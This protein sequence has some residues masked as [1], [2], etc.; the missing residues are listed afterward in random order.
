M[1][2]RRATQILAVVALLAA[3]FLLSSDPQRAETQP[4]QVI[5]LGQRV[6]ASSCA[7][8]HMR[9]AEAQVPGLVF[10]HGNHLMIGCSACHSPQPHNDG[11]TDRPPMD[12][13]F[14]CHGINHGAQG[15]LATKEC[16]DC[17]TPSFNLRPRSHTEDWAAKPHADAG[18]A[19]G[20][21]RCLMC[22][23]A[24]T[25]CDA[26]HAEQVPD[27]GKMP[28]AFQ[29]V[30]LVK[31]GPPTV[32]IY[33]QERVTMGQCVSC[34]PDVDD[35]MPGSVIFEHSE[36]LR[37]SY[38]CEVCHVQFP[39]GNDVIER[40][41]ME[42]CY[43]CHGLTHAAS[44]LVAREECEACHPPE[45]DLRPENHTD[46]FVKGEH[47]NRALADGA[48]CGMC[49]EEKFC[50]DCHQGRRLGPDGKPVEPVIPEDHYEPEWVFG[51]HG[52]RFMEQ[53]GMCGS[54]HESQGCKRCH[55]TPMP[56]PADWLEN[57]SAG[58]EPRDCNVCH[59]NRDRCQ[60]CHH[61]QVKR[62]ELVREACTPCH[63]EMNHIP[64]TEIRHK[65]YAEHAVHFDVVKK[66]KERPYRCEDCHVSFGTSAGARAAEVATAHDLRLCY[67]CHGGLDYQNVQIA[68]WK[69]RDLCARCHPRFKDL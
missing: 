47:K 58:E 44:G 13:C 53:E 28:S 39:H 18:K 34:H 46:P 43:R 12:V 14:N 56:H 69:G 29:P 19:G 36:H 45:F 1:G 40:P 38:Q 32:R 23:D 51:N 66:G 59:V 62:A 37:R 63:D 6:D 57:H 16:S 5:E 65:G 55:Q 3:A 7:P 50:V 24:P 10:T 4:Y 61:D 22:H 9:I 35:F 27:L 8:C 2:T 52:G 25:D 68:P 30:L 26:C 41:G 11:E 48:Y 42:G 60:G 64:P 67:E 17:H 20:V 31:P 49:H 33:P 54:C 15:E 21:N